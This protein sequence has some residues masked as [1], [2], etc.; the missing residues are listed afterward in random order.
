[1]PIT[2]ITLRGMSRATS[3]INTPDGATAEL[4][5][6]VVENNEIRPMGLVT[7]DPIASEGT[8]LCIHSLGDGTKVYVFER[9]NGQANNPA[10]YIIFK[11]VYAGGSEG[12]VEVFTIPGKYVDVQAT[13]LGNVVVVSGAFGMYYF[14]YRDGHYEDLGQR[15]PFPKL[16]FGMYNNSQYYIAPKTLY[17]DADA[18]F[19]GGVLSESG[20]RA[21]YTD[22]QAKI[23]TFL[24]DCRKDGR[25]V[26]PFFVRYALRLFDGSGHILHSAP[27]LM[28]PSTDKI[29]FSVPSWLEDGTSLNGKKWW[30]T[31]FRGASSKLQFH[32]MTTDVAGKE[33]LSNLKKWKDLVSH[34]DIFI[35]S[36]IYSYKELTT[37]Y[38][39]EVGEFEEWGCLREIDAANYGYFF[40]HNLDSS[41]NTIGETLYGEDDPPGW[42]MV[43]PSYTTEE[44]YDNVKNTSLFYLVHSIPLEEIEDFRLT[45]WADVPL[46]D[47]VLNSL[48]TRQVLKDDFNSLAYKRGN[49]ME[50]YNQRLTIADMVFKPYE[51]YPLSTMKPII[52]EDNFQASMCTATT[53]R[54]GRNTII[55]NSESEGLSNPNMPQL[56]SRNFGF[57]YYPDPDAKSITIPV[58][59]ERGVVYRTFDLEPHASLNGAYLFLGYPG[60][61]T[62]FDSDNALPQP[63]ENGYYSEPNTIY[64]SQVGNPFSF[65]LD[66]ITSIGNA[67]LIALA[68]SSIEVSTGQ[69]GDYPMYAFTEEGIWILS[70]SKEGWISTPQLIS[71]DVCLGKDAIV[72]LNRPVVFAS[73]RGLMLLEGSKISC[74]SD[75]LLGPRQD[76]EHIWA[77]MGKVTKLDSHSDYLKSAKSEE[78]F[79]DFLSGEF[80]GSGGRTAFFAY[81]YPNNR[82]LIMHPQKW[83]AYV[84]SLSSLE[85]SKVTSVSKIQRAI[86][87]YDGVYIQDGSEVM[88][89]SKD[90]DTDG[91]NPQNVIVITRPVKF[92]S[93]AL[94]S[95]KRMLIRHNCDDPSWL[96]VIAYGSRDGE[97]YHRITSLRGR[98]YKYFIF[99]IFGN[100]KPSERLT[101]LSFDWNTKFTNKLR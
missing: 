23:N 4:I 81:D 92:G 10:A 20:L 98:S 68:A 64:Q 99:A 34:I 45:T 60:R 91:E 33:D 101:A 83:Y 97:N 29:P 57:Y 44:Q 37:D 1:M 72:S 2:D 40:G 5:N 43:L 16:A 6:A 35:S 47:D 15:P 69:M 27:I 54:K 46:E 88:K 71:H 18:D 8:L 82:L 14:L 28:N 25:F 24:G 77:D 41:P 66:G 63:T 42:E 95:I 17:L 93:P 74:L 32:S 31:G 39:P 12:D 94:K 62:Y 52:N 67:P 85:F 80:T 9:D 78:S 49:T 90:V 61:K 7:T 48:E 70:I 13:T 86:N 84:L 50:V 38:T 30:K 56:S 79:L 22:A 21:V 55:V 89:L 53:L 73:K 51:G 96:G 3:D 11:P 19:S 75:S 76:V 65:P 58:T 100:M 59:I 36:P 26:F 87:A